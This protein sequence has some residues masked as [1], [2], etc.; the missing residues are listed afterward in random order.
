MT[1]I[2][3]HFLERAEFNK[4]SKGVQSKLE[5]IVTTLQNSNESLKNQHERLKADGEQQY[6]DVEKRLAVCQEQLVQATRHL[7]KV[8]EE[9]KDLENELTLL[10]RFGETYENKTQQQKYD[11]EAE[12]REL[13]RLL[14]KK[15]HEAENLIAELNRLNEKLTE[16]EKVK[17]E[18]QLKLDDVQSSEASA[19]HCQRRIKQ[20]KELLEKKVEWLTEELESK[21]EELL[22]THR[23]KGSEILELQSNLKNCKEQSSSLEIQLISL[24]ET[25]ESNSKRVED[26][27]NK[28]KQSKEEQNTIELKYQNELTAH[29]KLSSL[30]K[31]AASD[32]ETKN[33]E[34]SRAVEELSIV[35]K[36]AK[37]ANDA[38][39]KKVLESKDLKAQFEAELQERLKK[40]EKE[41]ENSIVKAA[42]KHCCL[43]S[44]TEE[45]LESM[46]PSAA[47]I[48]A[49]VKPGMKFFDL[50]NAYM[51]C[52]TQLQLEKQKTRRMHQVVDEI[53]QEVESK[54]PVFKHQKEEYES[55]QK[56]VSSLWNKLEQARMEIYSLQKEKHEAMQHCERMENDKVKTER[57][58]QETSAQFCA[59][60]LELEESRGT[61]L[62]KA[63]GCVANT[64]VSGVIDT[65]QLSL[66][67]V[68][69]L[70]KEN[71]CLIQRLR[72][73]E[74]EKDRW[75]SQETLARVSELKADVDKLQKEA[76]YLREQM[77]QQKRLA[78]SSARQRDMYRALLLQGTGFSLPP[79]GLDYSVQPLHVKPSSPPTQPLSQ[80]S[81]AADLAQ[82]SQVKA[83]LKQLNDAFTL[84]KTEKAENDRMLNETNDKL[85]KQLTELQSS[86]A[87]CPAELE[88]VNKRYEMLQETL[89]AYRREIAMLQDK[90]RKM[91]AMTQQYELSIHTMNQDLRQA[92][93]KLAL[94]QV[95]SENLMKE[96]EILRQAEHRLGREKEVMLVEQRNQN[97]LL[98]NLKTIQMTMERSELETCH[99]LNTK[100]DHLEAEL[101]SVKTKLEQEV[102]QKHKLGH[103]MDAQLLEAQKQIETLNKLY[104]KTKELL[105]A[106]EQQV[107]TLQSKLTAASSSEA[108]GATCLKLQLRAPSQESNQADELQELKGQLH[109]TEQK[110]AE[111]TEQLKNTNAN[112][113]RYRVVV[114][115]LEETVKKEK[116]S[117]GPL[118][119]QVKESE[120]VQK[121]LEK[122]ILELEKM[123]RQEQQTRRHAIDE[124]EKHVSDLQHS[125]RASQNKEHEALERAAA[126]VTQ[127]QKA[128]QD[129]LLQTTVAAEAQA[130][131]ERELMLHAADVEA[132]QKLKKKA[133]EEAVKRSELE[134]QGSK[135][136]SL[137]QDKMAA[138]NIVE[139]Q[140]KEDLLNKCRQYAEME[141]QNAML[142]QQ[143][144]EMASRNTQI[145]EH[146]LL[147]LHQT[148]GEEGKTAEQLLEILRF[149]RQQKDIV[150]AQCEVSKREALRYRERM[151]QQNREIK[152]LQ[153]ALNAERMKVQVTSR[154]LAVQ[155]Q[156]LKKIEDDGVLQE[157]N[158]MLKMDKEKVE[159]ELLQ[160]QSR[161]TKLQSDINPLHHSLSVLSEKNGSL[162]AEKRLLEEDLK[163]WKI[164]TQQL[165]SQQK[166]NDTE[167]RQKIASE[168]RDQQRHISQLI[169]ET[170]NLKNE[171]SRYTYLQSTASCN[172]AQ[173][174]L[175][176]LR[177]SITHLTAERDTLKKDLEIK[178]N[179]IIEKSKTITQVKKIGRRYKSQYEALKSQHDK[180]VEEMSAKTKSVVGLDQEEN[181]A[182]KELLRVKEELNSLKEEAK[183]TLQALEEALK[184]TQELKEKCKDIQNQLIQKQNQ[185]AEVQSNLSEARN[186]LRQSQDELAQSQKD[187]HQ[188]NNNSQQTHNQ[189]KSI[190]SQELESQS[191]IQQLQRELQQA[192]EALQLNLDNQK[193]LQQGHTDEVTNF[194]TAVNQAE[195]KVK[196]L[197]ENLDS[198]QKIVDE[199]ETDVKCLQEQLGE[200]K[201]ATEDCKATAVNQ[202]QSYQFHHASDI[203]QA[204][205]KLIKLK[206]ELSEAK[207][208]E[209]Q[210]R[211][212]IAEKEEK[213]KRVFLGAKTKISQLNNSKVQ[214]GQE[215]EELK[216]SKKELEVRMNAL[217]CQYEGRLHRLDRELRELRDVRS[218][219]SEFS[220]EPQDHIGVKT[221]EQI[222][223]S[224]QRKISLKSPAHDR[225]SSS[226]SEPPTANIRPTPSTQSPGSKSSPTPG[227]KATPRASIRPMV[228]PTVPIP[229]PT[230]TV[231]PTT[232]T[233]NQEVAMN[234]GPSAQP[235]SSTQ[236]TAITAP[237]S[238]QTTAFVQ[239]TQQ[240]MGF[241]M[242]MEQP[243]TSSFISPAGSKRGREDDNEENRSES[244]HTTTTIKKSRLNPTPSLQ[245]CEE[246]EEEIEDNQ[247]KTM[248]LDDSQVI[249]SAQELSEENYSTQNEEKEILEQDGAS[250]SV[251][252]DPLSQNIAIVDMDSKSCESKQRE[253]HQDVIEE[254]QQKEDQEGEGKVEGIFEDDNTGDVE[255]RQSEDG[256]RAIMQTEEGGEGKNADTQNIEE[257]ICGKSDPRH[258]SEELHGGEGTSTAAMSESSFRKDPMHLLL[259]SSPSTIPPPSLSTPHPRRTSHHLP[260]RLYIQPP[261]PEMGSL[262]FQRQPLPLHRP[263]VGRG[264]QLTPGIGSMQHFFDDEDR[265]VPSTP[266]LVVPHRTDGFAEAIHSPQVAGLSTRF[267]FGPPEDVLTQAS[268]L[269]SD[270]GQ[271][272]S[273]GGTTYTSHDEAG[274][275][276]SVP[277]TPLQVAAPVTVFTESS[278]SVENITSQSVPMA[279]ASTVMAA[280]ADEGDEVFVDQEEENPGLVSSAETAA[281]P[282]S[283]VASAQQDEDPEN[284]NIPQQAGNSLPLVNRLSARGGS[285]ERR[286]PLSRRGAYTRGGRGGTRG[287]GGLV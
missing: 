97:L 117:R 86:H 53:V 237:A 191:Q 1:S 126:A 24:K 253:K 238:I 280:A 148:F 154:T 179:D 151:E 284:G 264:L 137:L 283:E 69:E 258:P 131:Y 159:Q 164:K 66:H 106:S 224:E 211:Q 14:E 7:Q 68:E 36:N 145:E 82:N 101:V 93:E 120:E 213:T 234:S 124:L 230:A 269:H 54:A 78:D 21:T 178:K 47:S 72:D 90:S 35:V 149:V 109:T 44:V 6:F 155:E 9:K 29:V 115:T 233:E 37:E 56:S 34:L 150:L 240:Q 61:C 174:Q 18:L 173:A 114:L 23:E 160:A 104:L 286:T 189:L 128:I 171:L 212:Q 182:D 246:S 166:D 119:I 274:G 262:L 89:S 219:H 70:H 59:V 249:F 102:A 22:N 48:A 42:G 236:L 4:L 275:G 281:E 153:E 143:M 285:G 107:A 25:S 41:L 225:G 136:L 239:P 19:Q 167:E 130:K 152:E 13:S 260:P 157:T 16:T 188:A 192:K 220:E 272:A 263:S 251:P 203:S 197:Q 2:L 221:G 55:M 223:S 111:L 271:L 67:S 52:Q 118:E 88:F 121:K 277:T 243:S 96:R 210:L 15:T 113:E 45:Q 287:R 183:K 199:R 139:K 125:L 17:M 141:K 94:E 217:K 11:A 170:T 241:S 98:S 83:A 214:L 103:C 142:H 156:Q 28:L 265:M 26:L 177:D 218:H 65:T 135:T 80:R 91:S 244:L 245:E 112:L 232:Q 39:E 231:M 132:I 100:I 190:Q 200:A 81:K 75:Q 43:P 8:N 216:Q 64:S 144:D 252:S 122:R 215:M 186:Q 206:Q 51:D 146:Q 255:I 250:Q 95:R 229:T 209:E 92:N 46:C 181:K 74:E 198:L 10:K 175:Q 87:K 84:Y 50:Y 127:E 208:R 227:S 140:L 32:L 147:Q 165:I 138:W 273:Q 105:L 259:S 267:R 60:L 185:L 76:E 12:K 169:E 204:E 73:I 163:R 247:E 205:D 228:T 77:T 195:I 256:N 196:E 276:R 207:N 248:V 79:E 168:R 129:S 268:S 110:N 38:L 31:E 5:K 63:E 278:D 270:L 254:A 123:K 85:Q 172:S 279:S 202:S 40:M 222:R 3:L 71:Q 242:D 33:Q 27:S 226:L 20:E 133:E 201:Q 58:L 116:E 266:T 161:V 257:N 57:Q 187:L 162:Q 158:R 62:T 194:K 99:R 235:S 261:A 184:E 176:S 49:I 134:K 108:V 193:E 180:L 282:E 30:Y